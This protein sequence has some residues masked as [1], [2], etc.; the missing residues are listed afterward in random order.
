MNYYNT[1]RDCVI[2]EA[3]DH[4]NSLPTFKRKKSI[5]DST[6]PLRVPSPNQTVSSEKKAPTIFEASPLIR[7]SSSP[8]KIARFFDTNIT[9]IE[10]TKTKG[11][12]GLNSFALDG[13]EIKEMPSYAANTSNVSNAN[14]F[15]VD[16]S[17]MM[18]STNFFSDVVKMQG[19]GA[20]VSNGVGKSPQR[21][22][23]ESLCTSDDE[24]FLRTPARASNEKSNSSDGG[25]SPKSVPT[26]PTGPSA[27]TRTFS[28]SE[29]MFSL[30]GHASNNFSSG[31]RTLRASQWR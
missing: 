14:K 24:T 29:A 8:L 12:D 28:Y 15:G 9:T 17:P 13:A 11:K 23:V 16:T 27:L 18:E 4:T 26:S 22:R 6:R 10:E 2:S 1:N 25:S 30:P 19:E 20:K 5:D 7:P 31:P 3:K 21:P